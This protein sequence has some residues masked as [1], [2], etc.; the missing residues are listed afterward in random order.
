M[1]FSSSCVSFVRVALGGLW[2]IVKT[3]LPNRQAT[4]LKDVPVL[5]W[6]NKRSESF[7]CVC[8]SV[9]LKYVLSQVGPGSLQ[10]KLLKVYI[11]ISYF[12]MPYDRAGRVN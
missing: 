11:Y 9:T 1:M 4:K 3:F 5:S 10:I 7:T 12:T 6:S 2:A 8:Q